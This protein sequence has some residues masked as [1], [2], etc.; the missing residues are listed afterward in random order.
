MKSKKVTS[1]SME[2]KNCNRCYEEKDRVGDKKLLVKM[3]RDL[4]ALKKE[5]W[6]QY[7]F[8]QDPLKEKISDK[9]KKVLMNQAIECGKDF[10]QKVCGKYKTRDPD[11][12]AEK[13]KI[14]VS[15]LSDDNL[16]FPLFAQ[17]YEPNQIQLNERLICQAEQLTADP[18][19]AAVLSD[20]FEVLKLILAHEIFHHVEEQYKNQIFT[21]NE[22]IRLW[23]FGP[24]HNDS[25][26]LSLSEI[27]AMTFACEITKTSYSPY[28][29]DV[30]LL[31]EEDSTAAF[32]IYKEMMEGSRNDGEE[33]R[34]NVK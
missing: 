27:G 30:L 18:E 10:G 19:I 14:Q 15:S 33:E 12:L 24:F 21:Q 26:I 17:Y 32:D 23:S 1:G 4:M 25:K 11:Q 20:G 13:M 5:D 28:L 3:L 9:Q 31:F 16:T 2:K 8:N 29:I 34:R 7:A 6:C 22:K